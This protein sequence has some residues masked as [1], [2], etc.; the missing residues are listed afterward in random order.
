MQWLTPIGSITESNPSMGS[1]AFAPPDN[2]RKRGCWFAEEC[3]P[4]LASSIPLDPRGEVFISMSTWQRGS[5]SSKFIHCFNGLSTNCNEL[6]AGCN[7]HGSLMTR[8]YFYCFY[9]F[10]F[11][12]FSPLNLSEGI[13]LSVF[14]FSEY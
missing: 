2:A 9:C 13:C 14:N 6:S 5:A 3:C 8:I 4:L 1:F 12:I 10:Y 7:S 11:F